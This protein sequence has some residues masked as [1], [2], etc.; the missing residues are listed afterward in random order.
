MYQGYKI[1]TILREIEKKKAVNINEFDCTSHLYGS[2]LADKKQ[3]R[4][5]A[6]SLVKKKLVNNKDNIL[7][8]TLVGKDWLAQK[9]QKFA[10]N[11]K[12]VNGWQ[13]VQ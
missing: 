1:E 11:Y 7:T 10:V 4:E 3:F 8:L 2:T 6:R 5:Y 13:L 12:I 9:D